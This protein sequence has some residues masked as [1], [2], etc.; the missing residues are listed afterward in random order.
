MEHLP[1]PLLLF[2]KSTPDLVFPCRCDP[3][4]CDD[5]PLETYPERRGFSLNYWDDIMKFANILKL[6]DGSKPDVEQSTTLMQE[7][8]FFGL[9]RAMHRSYGTEFKGSDYI[10]VVHGNRVLTLKRLPEHVQ[11]WYELEGERPRAIRKRHFHEIEAHLIRALRFLSNNFT[12]DNAG[13]RGPT[14]PWYVVPVVS[15]VVL[16]SNL[17]ILLLVLTEAME[18]ITQAILFQ[19][20]RVNYD[21]ASACVCFSTNALVERLAWCPSE[22]NLLRLTFDNSSF[23]FASLLKRTTNKA[24]HAKCTSN[25]CLAF[26]LKQ[27]DYQPGHLR[28]CDGCRAISINSAEL[29]QILESNDESAYPRVKITITDDDEINLSMTNTGS[30][31]AISHVWSDG[32]GHPPGVNSLPACQVRRL[33][34]LVMEAGLEQ[35][36]IW[37]DSLCVP[38]DSGL[39]KRNALGRM[40][41]VYTNAKNVFV[42]DSDLVSIPSSCC[43]EEL[44]LRIALS[45]WMRRLW[46]LEEGVVGR[47]NLLFRFQDR[48]IPLPA[49]NASFTDNVSINCMTLMLQYL[50]AKTDIVSVITALHFR[51][52]TRNGDEPLCIGYILGLDVSYIV[53]IEVFD[54]RMLELYCLLTK[55]DP[56]FPFQFL[57]TDEGKLNYSPFRWAPRS[58]LNLEAHDIFYIQCM[59]DASQYQIKATQ[60][61]RG[62]RCQGNFSSCLLAFEEALTSKNA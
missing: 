17:E 49:V 10:A 27:S 56:S 8:L 25:K 52:T 33:K 29:R 28:G 55:K 47:S 46:T 20:R 51:S 19:E 40:A 14:G 60:T 53:S 24:S 18:H 58:L 2:D 35:S 59:V 34:S 9:L 21:P 39:A 30:Y 50:P 42:L 61:D 38:C 26:E 11:T 48:A 62:L 5:G 43:N 45:K 23:Y 36:P 7:W 32:L 6:A 54:K 31:I 41:K 16:E 57:F 22:L 44:L 37:I 12:E 13:S 1:R 4:L 3:D 15:Q